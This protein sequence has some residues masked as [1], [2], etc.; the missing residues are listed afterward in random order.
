MPFDVDEMLDGEGDMGEGDKTDKDWRCALA[1]SP[2]EF[3]LNQKIKQTYI[4]SL[5]RGGL[6]PAVVVS[7]GCPGIMT[8]PTVAH[9]LAFT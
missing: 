5:P 1:Q 9:I 8:S 7:K 3:T 4:V 6:F 2:D